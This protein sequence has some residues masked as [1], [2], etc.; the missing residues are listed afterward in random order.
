VQ[1]LDVL[2]LLDADAQSDLSASLVRRIEE[3]VRT[4][5]HAMGTVELSRKDIPPC[6][7]CLRCLT[8]HPGSCAYKACFDGIAE[9]ASSCPVIIFLT[10]A[11]F[12]TFS[13]AVK[14]VIDRGAL[15]IRNRGRCRQVIIGYG[16]D[17]TDEE[18]ATFIDVTVKHRG[19]ADIVHP[20]VNETFEVYFARSQ[21]D[22]EGI[23][24][25]LA[26]AL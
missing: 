26:G 17:A 9:Q 14:N 23:S 10:S 6:T 21:K 24:A 4:K 7:G 15:V 5:Q 11:P 22:C 3:M 20:G 1:A 19:G 13:S 8:A 16:E 18:R 2:I 12:G 25:A